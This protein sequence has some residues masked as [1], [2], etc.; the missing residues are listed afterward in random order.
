MAIDLTRSSSVII[1][2]DE[3]PQWINVGDVTE[4]AANTL[5]TEDVTALLA[6]T[7]APNSMGKG[8]HGVMVWEVFKWESQLNQPDNESGQANNNVK[9]S[10]WGSF[11]DDA[12]TSVGFDDEEIQY[13]RRATIQNVQAA[14]GESATVFED[15]ARVD[16]GDGAGRG[17]L[18]VDRNYFLTVE[19][20]GNANAKSFVVRMKARRVTIKLVE[21]LIEILG[22]GDQALRLL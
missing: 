2:G 5:T 15:I 12:P 8:K 17:T 16:E 18:L 21:A 1:E 19:G 13:Y 14:A 6:P 22:I 9:A 3:Y 7:I 4:S 10:V 11:D 20:T